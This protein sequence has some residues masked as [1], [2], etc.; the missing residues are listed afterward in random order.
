MGIEIKEQTKEIIIRLWSH[1]LQHQINWKK[2]DHLSQKVRPFKFNGQLKISGLFTLFK[3]L[4][5]KNLSFKNLA[6]KNL[7]L[8]V[9]FL[10]GRVLVLVG[11]LISR[12]SS[13]QRGTLRE[14]ESGREVK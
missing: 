8:F 2:S 6:F 4:S 10:Y 3:N 9:F 11:E 7:S 1:D 13:P 5:F 12:W 14:R